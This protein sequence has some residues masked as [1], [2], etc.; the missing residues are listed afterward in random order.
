MFSG[1][2]RSGACAHIGLG[3]QNLG[4]AGLQEHVVKGEPLAN[5]HGEASFS[6]A[7]PT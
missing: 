1:D 7:G 5:L 3:G 4:R 2:G 6:L